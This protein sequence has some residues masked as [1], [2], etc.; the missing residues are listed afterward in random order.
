MAEKDV[1]ELQIT[2]D[3]LVVVH[4]GARFHDLPHVVPHLWFCQSFAP[5]DQLHESLEH[6]EEEHCIRV[7]VFFTFDIH[8]QDSNSKHVPCFHTAPRSNIQS[9]YPR[10]IPGSAQY[11]CG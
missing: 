2:M 9:H 10:D 8:G 7:C 3:D 5:L 6:S 11:T 1:A 4:E